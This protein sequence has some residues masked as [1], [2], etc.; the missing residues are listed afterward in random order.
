[1]DDAST[2][3]LTDAVAST[4]SHR[5]LRIRFHRRDASGG[6]AAARN[7]GLKLAEGDYIS[8]LDDDDTLAPNA[9]EATMA[10]LNDHPAA[11]ACSSWHQV[12]HSTSRAEVFRG[13]TRCEADVLRWYNS[14]GILFGVFRRSTAGHVLSFDPQLQACE[15]WDLWLRLAGIQPIAVLPVPLYA[16]HQHTSA[17]VSRGDGV[18]AAGRATFLR[19]HRTSMSAG[20][21]AYHAG[22]IAL[23]EGRARTAALATLL[24]QGPFA[25]AQAAALLSMQYVAVRGGLRLE[26]PGLPARTVTQLIQ[27]HLTQ[28]S[29]IRPRRGESHSGLDRSASTGGEDER[30]PLIGR[31]DPRRMPPRHLDIAR[32]V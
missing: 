5:D 4:F 16:Y 6:P 21:I 2:E 23:L 3:P 32:D 25:A 8:F 10:W 22:C 15:D 13:P 1:M 29:L 27:G 28:S 18:G 31:L 26:D 14:I 30:G 7:D 24:Q 17:R 9:I 20:C 11:V 19:K 12:I